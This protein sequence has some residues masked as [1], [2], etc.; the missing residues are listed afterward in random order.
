MVLRRAIYARS[1][2]IQR[3]FASEN[4]TGAIMV[5]DGTA[6]KVVGSRASECRGCATLPIDMGLSRMRGA[7]GAEKPNRVGRGR[8]SD[9][10]ELRTDLRCG[11]RTGLPRGARLQPVHQDW[12]AHQLKGRSVSPMATPGTGNAPEQVS[13]DYRKKLH[14][15]A[16]YHG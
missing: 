16:A 9:V 4:S 10:P 2:N 8:S 15:P 3:V 1:R 14:Y 12:E 6:K 13:Q 7:E 11:K 5:P